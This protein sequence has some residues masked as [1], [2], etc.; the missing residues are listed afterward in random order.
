[1]F[2]SFLFPLSFS[3]ALFLSLYLSLCQ[4][5][6]LSVSVYLRLSL[7]LSL[8]LPL[9]LS[10]SLLPSLSRSLPVCKYTGKDFNVALNTSEICARYILSQYALECITAVMDSFRWGKTL[11]LI[12]DARSHHMRMEVDP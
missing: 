7:S 5:M 10:L 1:M 2:V 9:S 4:C 8:P 11:L 6:C 12:E 3:H